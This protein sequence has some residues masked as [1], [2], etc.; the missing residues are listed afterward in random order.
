LIQSQVSL[1]I[2]IPHEIPLQSPY[3]FLRRSQTCLK[4]PTNWAKMLPRPIFREPGPRP[5]AL[6]IPARLS[7]ARW[8]TLLRSAAA[9]QRS[10]SRAADA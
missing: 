8:A 7:R 9:A 2:A 5:H 10:G 3:R 1:T 6:T 4:T